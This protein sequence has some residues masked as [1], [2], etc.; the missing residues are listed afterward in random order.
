MDFDELDFLRR[1]DPAWR[2]LRA[3]NA[4]LV[5]GFLRK[6]F[7]DDNVRSISAT[8]LISRLDDELYALNERFGEGSFPK[9]AKAYVDEGQGADGTRK[10]QWPARRRGETASRLRKTA[11]R[12]GSK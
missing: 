5:L 9:A 3:D 4:P 11:T 10:A 12:A 1:N 7:V 2:L 8:E 6:V